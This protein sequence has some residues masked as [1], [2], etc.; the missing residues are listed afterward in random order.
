MN[1]IFRLVFNHALG[2]VQVV[3]ELARRAGPAV[4]G[5]RAAPQRTR[6]LLA[7]M[8]L[9]AGAWGQL[10]V[11]TLPTDGVPTGG[12]AT[13]D[14]TVPGVLT[15]V[16]SG[17]T[18]I[19]WEAFSIGEQARV[20]FDQT[21]GSIALNRVTGSTASQIL[22]TL[23]ASAGIFL[24]N[25]RGILF[26]AGAS[27][28]VGSLLATTLEPGPEFPGDQRDALTR[29]VDG[30]GQLNLVSVGAPGLVINQG[31]LTTRASGGSISLVGGSVRNEAGARIVADRGQ[32]NLVGAGAADVSLSAAH[33]VVPRATT[34]PAD[35][36]TILVDNA[37]RVQA[38]GGGI[39]M[40]G[41]PGLA[42]VGIAVNTSGIVSATT[43]DGIA[44][45]VDMRGGDA[46]LV[47]GGEVVAA[48]TLGLVSHR[49]V[50]LTGDISAGTLT[51]TGADITQSGGAGSRVRSSETRLTADS[52]G[53]NGDIALDSRGNVFG[54]STFFHGRNVSL[55]GSGD[56]EIG[57][58]NG[59]GLDALRASGSLSLDM[60]GVIAQ[61][62][63]V[64]V[65]GTA[66]IVTDGRAI[67]LDHGGNAF[68]GRVDL[69]G[70]AVQLANAGALMLG[71]VAATS[72]AV[73]A[74][75]AV[76][77]SLGT[78]I[79]VSGAT[80]IDANGA[81]ITLANAGNDF[82]DTVA[83][84]GGVT[85]IRDG[86][87]LTLGTLSTGALTVEAGGALD[88]GQGSVGLLVATS[89]GPITQSGNLVFG[90]ANQTSLLDAGGTGAITL[91]RL[92]NVANGRVSVT[93]GDVVMRSATG[94][95][96]DDVSTAGLNVS[97]SG[98]VSLGRGQITGNLTATTSGV[99][100]QGGA[101]AVTGTTS[102]DA[103]AGGITLANPGNAFGGAVS[104]RGG[105]TTIQAGGTLRLASAAT[106]SLAATAGAIQLGGS[107][108]SSGPQTF[109]GPVRLV[110]D[111]VLNGT[112]L[113]L[114]GALDGA[115]A[116]TA[117]TSGNASFGGAVGAVDRL[118]AFSVDA[119][120][121]ST[122]STV[123]V[124][125]PL[126]MSVVSGGI[127]QGGAFTIAGPAA[128]SAGAGTIALDRSDNDFGG[129]VDL[130]GSV[131]RLRDANALVLGA[132][133][134]GTL[135]ARSGLTLS[136]Q[137]AIDVTGDASFIADTPGDL[138][139]ARDDNRFGGTVSLA[140]R[141]VAIASADRLRLGA[142]AA[143]SLVA[144]APRIELPAS[145]QTS[146][147]QVYR[148][149][150]ILVADTALTS[151]SGDIRFDGAL[152]GAHALRVDAAD[153]LV[154]GGAAGG[155]TA[156][157][158]LDA[159]ASGLTRL[160]GDVTATGD[161]RVSDLEVAAADS[162]VRSTAG[163]IRVDGATEAGGP[164]QGALDLRAADAV[165]LVGD[166]GA[167][168]ALSRLAIDGASVDTAGIRVDDTLS[169]RS[170]TGLAQRGDYR[171]GGD[172]TFESAGDIVL[173]RDGNRFGGQVALRGRDVTL[174]T[175]GAVSLGAVQADALAVRSGATITQGAGLDIGG[176]LLL[177]A[178]DDIALRAADNRFGGDVRATAG[179]DLALR[180]AGTLHAVAITAGTDADVSLRADA[181]DLQTAIDTGQGGL[182]LVADADTLVITNAL[183]GSTVELEG[184]SGVVLAADVVGRDALA[185]S[186]A[187]GTILQTGGTVAGGTTA[188]DAAGDVILGSAGNDFTGTVSVRGRDVRLRDANS[189]VLGRVEARSLDIEAAT[190]A[191]GGA[192]ATSGGQRW[193]GDVTLAG[194]VSLESAAGDLLF[195][196]RV[197]SASDATGALAARA[198]AGDVRFRGPVGGLRALEAL[199]VA[200]GAVTLEGALAVRDRLSITAAQGGI[201]Q[202]AA[203]DVGGDARFVAGSGDIRL[204]RAGN[205]FRGAV[206]LEG[207]S[208]SIA[209][210]N[211]LRLG[212]VEAAALAVS[213]GDG[214]SFEGQV[215]VDGAL[216]ATAGGDIVQTAAGTIAA[217]DA[218][219]V[220]G[221]DI[222][223][224]AAGNAFAGTVDLE[225]ERIVLADADTL[226]LGAVDASSLDV[227]A[228]DALAF[229]GTTRV[230]GRLDARAGGAVGQTGAGALIVGGGAAFEAGGN[231]D[232]AG[233]G[234]VFG[235]P[236]DLAG[237]AVAISGGQTLALGRT[238]VGALVASGAGALV[239]SASA[240]I[241]GALTATSGGGITQGA[242]ADLG[243]GGD[244]VFT[245][246]GAIDLR[247][248]DNDF[249]GAVSLA[250]TGVAI[251][252]ANALRLGTVDAASLDVVAHDGVHFGTATR[253]AGPLA[254]EAGT[255]AIEQDGALTVAGTSRFSTGGDISLDN[256]A[257][258]FGGRV[259]LA[260]DSIRIAAVDTLALGT[261]DAGSL[262]VLA[263]R[264]ALRGDV[265]TDDDQVFEGDVLIDGDTSL[266][267]GGDVRVSGAT[268]G[269]GAL[270]V[271]A[272]GNAAFE[273]AV[274]LTEL[275][276]D[277]GRVTFG[278]T[279]ATADALSINAAA[280]GITQAAGFSVGGAARF[281]ANGA[282]ITLNRDDN[283]FAG[284]VEL[285]GGAVS[286]ADA[287]ALTLGSVDAATL[288]V[289][290]RGALALG[291]AAITGTFDA[292]SGGFAITQ[293]GALAVAG[294]TT[295]RG[296]DI[297]LADPDNDFGGT[298][299]LQG[300]AVRIR[301]A[302]T[303]ALGV[304]RA[305]AFDAQSRRGMELGDVRIERELIARS[306]DGIGQLAALR[307][308][309]S[310]I[311]DGGSG[312]IRLDDAGNDFAAPVDVAGR[313]IS[314]R[315]ANDLVLA[316]LASGTDRDVQLVAGGA[317]SL[318]AQTLDTGTGA[319]R[320]SAL[321]GVLATRG[322]LSGGDVDL[323]GAGG[324][325]LGHDVDSRGQLTLRSGGDLTQTGG[326]IAAGTLTGVVA[327]KA[328]MEGA[329]AIGRLGAF[330]ATGV[331][332]ANTQALTLAGPLA[333]GATLHLR[334]A[335]DLAI[336]APV[337]AEALRLEAD[338]GI[339][340]SIDGRLIAGQLS[341]RAGGAVD[342]GNATRVV[343]NQVDRIGD[344]AAR[345]GFNMTN[346]RTLTLGAFNGSRF[347]IDAGTSDFFLSVDG[348]L[349]QDGTD[350]L[351]NGRGTWAATGA[352]GRSASPIYVTGLSMQT[353]SAI[354]SPP[355]YFYALRPDGSL[356]PIGGAAAVNVPT[357]VWAGR[358]QAS[359]N[360]QVAYV[361]VG[362]DASNYRAYGIVGA[363]IRLPDDQAPECDPDFPSDECAD[364]AQ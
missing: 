97:A 256:P 219:F 309:G 17:R 183:R 26:G 16:Q 358:A 237:G 261:I 112:S 241:E 81:A 194:E 305:G 24:I 174:H 167:G 89:G 213:A 264:I 134:A 9:P 39:A 23:D 265:A 128:F 41:T 204:D 31:A 283:D 196:G 347:T 205:D 45:R 18:V 93:G 220:A 222:D 132:V 312:D 56:F 5:M 142:V 301:D 297:T 362:A 13:F 217:Q 6:M 341:G 281:D 325:T 101:L 138:Q 147:Q 270:A 143:E 144:A 280:G 186:S 339:T 55:A 72:L 218:R 349:L 37:G 32:V 95:V 187:A 20:N 273:G 269:P 7:L 140:G 224:A 60:H 42:Q 248:V 12:S 223:L 337:S 159:R 253:V 145:L 43:L 352:I 203:F 40:I 53:Q 83:L 107:F 326:R 360:R 208:V 333:A 354:G 319:L 292:D 295:L 278:S 308:G 226:W 11:G 161:I 193:R 210:T 3:S 296:G 179:G 115:Y 34:G 155:N 63:G 353:V 173:D 188:L 356:L 335:G 286:I 14:S 146:G 82:R 104:L 249:V 266:S 49:A 322:A 330:S 94:L 35:G 355:A 52:A 255:G 197:D 240:R 198:A 84:R 86:N 151:L 200:G 66:S 207:A 10:P 311:L 359:S 338:G 33:E 254:V 65:D 169:V 2:Q 15:I 331:H 263:G 287:N 176:D 234:N 48:G 102:I 28:N 73:T 79:D 98:G 230:A 191:L 190:I 251:A 133:T 129:R 57:G 206:E 212:A 62:D 88:L 343:D 130:A 171:A 262:R 340:Q 185:V 118:R 85:R 165:V 67:T 135:S 136:Q 148:G 78:A 245:A 119:R 258:R 44:G 228:G 163:G 117:A 181:L 22:G 239:F 137:G 235:G 177:Q 238:D 364:A 288:D 244:S 74:N 77:Q 108:T 313:A 64:R 59:V 300:G 25:P 30:D 268:T 96:L 290:S 336:D 92:G 105:T 99:V 100:I 160:G 344:F 157:A 172:A 348:D 71:D 201:A 122:A 1:R 289:R 314:L 202:A 247:A 294:A 126:S 252:D 29:F 231:I 351:Y 184:R 91:D 291:P 192:I 279:V 131:V 327:G 90:A 299:S 310:A 149:D 277:A 182:T 357:S 318:P 121:L 4:R 233:A 109:T 175:G 315:D 346:G 189:L 303:L 320:V 123:S 332:L 246:G 209:D 334:V 282:E 124:D 361:D 54:G 232:L 260:G 68:N 316:R 69:A 306:G 156:L 103:N 38:D 51:A 345:G 229:S 328:R 267:A 75:G 178:A 329:N 257:N 342:L 317:L 36:V 168:T 211:A 76:S 236:V 214:L 221:G 125:G 170:S 21:A 271:A 216:T 8:L 307:V 272:V 58:G 275:S 46:D 195:D 225:G 61:R 141:N 114:S 80:A 152:D 111:T 293:T 158:S 243:V 321:G 350:W 154:L 19:E 110:G 47:V 139:L 162:T 302:G 127:N 259:A 27:V 116:L 276:I 284:T 323:Q 70:G 50:H 166:V 164:G 250:G 285:R 113:S 324:I 215:G 298:V 120:S 274:G 304:V 363:G 106:T 153:T 227:R 242:G 180:S 150:S 199:T 87:A